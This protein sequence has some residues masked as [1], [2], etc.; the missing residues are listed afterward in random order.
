M[1]HQCGSPRLIPGPRGLTA[2]CEQLSPSTLT[3]ENAELGPL[4]VACWSWRLQASSLHT[5]EIQG[6]PLDLRAAEG[7]WAPGP[8]SPEQAGERAGTAPR[9]HVP[10]SPTHS[11]PLITRHTHVMKNVFILNQSTKQ[12]LAK[13][14]TK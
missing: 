10:M 14:H 6:Q 9:G 13:Q 2:A 12:I 7:P 3:W 5:G 1:A 11:Q 4:A 8:P